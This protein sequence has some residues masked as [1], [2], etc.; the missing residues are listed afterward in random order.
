MGDQEKTPAFSCFV[1]FRLCLGLLCRRL[2]LEQRW[3]AMD[4]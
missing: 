4:S 2:T 1:F 3:L